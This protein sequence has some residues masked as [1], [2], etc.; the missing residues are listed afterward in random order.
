[1]NYKRGLDEDEEP[2]PVSPKIGP[3]IV[4]INSYH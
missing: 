1:M 3:Y 2:F 4:I